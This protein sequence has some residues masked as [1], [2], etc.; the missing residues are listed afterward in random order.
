MIRQENNI[1][2]EK[3]DTS[4]IKIYKARK[5]LRFSLN[6]KILN[7]TFYNFAKNNTKPHN[8]YNIPQFSDFIFLFYFLLKI[9]IL[10]TV[11]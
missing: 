1:K 9:V 6:M 7:D 11:R 3:N 4:T 2:D 8:I 10:N 5:K